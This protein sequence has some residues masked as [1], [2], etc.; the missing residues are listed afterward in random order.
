MTQ[1]D[2]TT[3]ISAVIYLLKF[4][5]FFFFLGIFI[6][7]NFLRSYFFL[8]TFSFFFLLSFFFLNTYFLFF[9]KSYVLFYALK[10][11]K[12]NIFKTN[13]FLKTS[14]KNFYNND[15]SRT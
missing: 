6:L 2:I 8:S 12:L 15:I 11:K 3:Y 14:N 7:F 4:L 10:L 9:F 13:A 1:M 5:L